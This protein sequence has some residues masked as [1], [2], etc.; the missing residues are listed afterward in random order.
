L[1]RGVD[2]YQ[3]ECHLFYLINHHYDRK[4]WN[5]FF[6]FYTH[7]GGARFTIGVSLC[8]LLSSLLSSHQLG[9]QMAAALAASHLPVALMK[10]C[11][12]RKRPYLVLSETKVSDNPLSDHSFP[13]GHTTAIFSIV[14]PVVIQL[15]LIGAL[16]LPVAFLVGVSRIFLGLHYPSDVLVGVLLGT[17]AGVGSV[18][19]I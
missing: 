5:S 17:L 14:T 3:L 13:S 11:Y 2:L 9:L 12:P 6:H 1:K 7:A 15:P 8:V 16:L 10:K 4:R 18:L 19:L